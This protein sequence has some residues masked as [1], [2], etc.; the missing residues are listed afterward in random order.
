MSYLINLCI[1]IINL[2]VYVHRINSDLSDQKQRNEEITRKL[3]R[4][5]TI[6]D[7]YLRKHPSKK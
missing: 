1:A 5:E 7:I 6:L 3:I 4:L 2:P